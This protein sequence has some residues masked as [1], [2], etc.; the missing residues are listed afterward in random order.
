[1][2][3]LA[4]KELIDVDLDHV[5]FDGNAHAVFT[6]LG[7]EVVEPLKTDDSPFAVLDQD[8]QG[9]AMIPAV[10]RIVAAMGWYAQRV[11]KNCKRSLTNPA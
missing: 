5:D 9:I 10:S 2:Q 7:G 3:R 8:L 4:F 1:M 6:L 11:Q